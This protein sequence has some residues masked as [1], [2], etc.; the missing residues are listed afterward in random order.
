MADLNLAGELLAGGLAPNSP[1]RILWGRLQGGQV[2]LDDAPD[3]PV[4][5]DNAA[6]ALLDGQRVMCI[7]QQGRF[8][9]LGPVRDAPSPTAGS[10][11]NGSWWRSPDGLQVCWVHT[12]TIRAATA[13]Y[14]G[15]LHQSRWQWHFPMPFWGQPVATCS[16][17][18]WSTGASWGTTSGAPSSTSVL[19][20]GIDG[21]PRTVADPL[22]ICATAVGR[23]RS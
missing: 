19:L 18:L 23:W 13:P 3:H 11:T 2:Y 5:A 12:T 9:I 15:V 6:G 17:W 22:V 7:H 8:T 4:F 21:V 14:G 20:R 10:N 1:L 16:T